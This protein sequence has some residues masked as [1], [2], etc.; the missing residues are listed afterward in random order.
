[1]DNFEQIEKYVSGRMTETE[2]SAFESQLTTDPALKNEFALQRSIIHGIQKARIA[3]LKT[4]LS[5]IPVTSAV[6][7]GLATGK[8]VAGVVAATVVATASYFYFKPANTAPVTAKNESIKTEIK[9]EKPIQ[10]ETINSNKQEEVTAATS[11]KSSSHKPTPSIPAATKAKPKINVLDPTEELTTPATPSA[12]AKED[13]LSATVAVSHVAVEVNNSEKK[14]SF[15]YQFQNGRL[16]LYGA[17]DDGLYE[18]L[19]IHGDAPSLF[20]YYKNSYYLL[21][22]KQTDITPLSAI[23]NTQ[24]IQKLKEYRSRQN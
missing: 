4:M 19:E 7:A 1:M 9:K 8:L 24:L 15:H 2:K 14:Y 20:L 12:K 11:V 18:I 13:V 22:E 3:E 23:Q 21:N 17:F 10:P 5:Q 16:V 6:S